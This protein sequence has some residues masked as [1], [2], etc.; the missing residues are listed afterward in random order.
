MTSSPFHPSTRSKGAF[1]INIC[2]NALLGM[3]IFFALIFV[4]YLGRNGA[5][6]F[7]VLG[8]AMQARRLDLAWRDIR[9]YWWLCLLP[10]WAITSFLWSDHPALSLRH[11]FQLLI[12]F[13]IAITLANRLA[14]LLLMQM[15]F[16]ALIVAAV[17]SLLIG[18]VRP[19]GIWIGIFESKNY[20][21]FTMVVLLLLSLAFVID[22]K[23]TGQWRMAGAIGAALALPQLFFAESL[24]A[25]IA[26]VCVI[27]AAAVLLRIQVLAP[28]R[29]PKAIFKLC[30][31]IAVTFLVG[32]YF[33]EAMFQLVF[34]LTGKD[35]TLTGRTDLWAV[36]LSEIASAPLSG[37]G[38]RA[39]WVHGN[40]TAE[41]L[42]AEFYIAARSGFNFHNLY[43]SN[44]VEIGL[45]GVV[46]QVGLLAT[47]FILCIRWLLRSG[48]AAPLFFFMIVSFVIVLSFVEVPVFSEFSTL[49]VMTLGAIIYG[50]RASR[51]LA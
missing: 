4:S 29:Q 28:A 43:L 39:F 38:Y 46:A 11:G 7:L 12:T 16:V 41:M 40:S 26:A 19:D 23:Q 5:L 17:S 42:W 36:A 21:A 9:E 37:S 34:E 20:Y 1:E 32:L 10:L 14:P 8:L 31:I 25:M 47:G 22:K 50:I 45:L 13:A 15:L 2:P 6:I 51:E 27:V 49:S 44:A 24:G 18:D 48:G 33:S 30:V 3:G 35:P